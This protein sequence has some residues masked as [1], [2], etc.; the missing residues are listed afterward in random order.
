MKRLLATV[1]LMWAVPC[2]AAAQT[3][4]TKPGPE[5]QKLGIFVGDWTYEGQTKAT[6]LGPAGPYTGKM[7]ARL[8]LG[9]FCVEFRGEEKGPAG[10]QEWIEIDSYD[11]VAKKFTWNAFDSGGGTQTVTYTFEGTTASVSGIQ[12]AGG[13]Q[14][15]MRATVVFAADLKS[16]VQKNEILV[17]GKWVLSAESKSAKVR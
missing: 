9:G 14:Y 13:K 5:H 16:F 15:Q 17:D 6:P 8:I 11:P 4:P 3:A 2:L 12:V 1:V 10:A 7:S